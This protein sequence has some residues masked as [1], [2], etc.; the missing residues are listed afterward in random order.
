MTDH[1]ISANFDA[2]SFV[3]ANGDG[4]SENEKKIITAMAEALGGP[5]W[6]HPMVV[7]EATKIYKAVMAM[8]RMVAELEG[9][10]ADVVFT[11]S[12]GTAGPLTMMRVVA[13][14]EDS[15]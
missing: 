5:N 4:P 12:G 13:K 2:T 3:N 14:L 11:A 1:T 6:E 10:G 9:S 8:M 15:G 7:F